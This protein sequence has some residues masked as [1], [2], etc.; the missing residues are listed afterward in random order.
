M[1]GEEAGQI[2]SAKERLT[3]QLNIADRETDAHHPAAARSTLREARSTLERADPQALTEQERLAG[4]VSL[5][6][7]SRAAGDAAFAN[8]ALDRALAVV[9]DLAP[10]ASRSEYVLGIEREVRGCAA[11]PPR[12]GCS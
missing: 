7:L 4:W 5:S 3:R 6:E 10:I 9:N 1:A 11:T 2:A 12:R 8:G